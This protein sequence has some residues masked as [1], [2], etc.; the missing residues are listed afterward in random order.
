[1]IYGMM[2]SMDDDTLLTH[3]PKKNDVIAPLKSWIATLNLVFAAKDGRSFLAKKQHIG[4][5]VI[6]K[7][8]HPEG[9]SICHGI[10]I[11]PPG[12]VAGGDALT[13]NIDVMPNASALITTPGAGKW[14]KAN[15]AVASQ[16]LQF[17]LGQG[18]RLE[19]FPQENI[20]FA[21][22][23]LQ[24]LA[25]I[26]LAEDASF[27]G[28]DILCFGRLAK[29]E[30]WNVGRLKQRLTIR[31]VQKCIWQEAANLYAQHAFFTSNI[32]LDGNV[33]SGTFVIAAGAL[34]A[35]LLAKCQAFEVDLSKD[36]S[37]Q[38]GVSALPEIVCA[39][40]VGMSTQSAR[41][42]FE[43]LWQILRPWYA[44]RVA[45]RPRIWNT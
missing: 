6:Q 32:G 4:P 24:F 33:V 41:Q 37:A 27:A 23:E 25:E 43:A 9:E 2:R 19:W 36:S 15:G 12:G 40:Y 28:W 18:A 14:Y 20:L 10:I 34:P 45:I 35:V 13:L 21:G 31:R 26:E 39:R 22:A 3:A 44:S 17:K 8:L 1:M 29:G 30:S 16:H 7:T 11:H 42:Y 38:Y 5:L